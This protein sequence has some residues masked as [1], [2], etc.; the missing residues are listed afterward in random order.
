MAKFG[1]KVK[2]LRFLVAQTSPSS[3]G[4]RD[5]ILRHYASLKSANP[6]VKFM[7]RESEGITPKVFAR[8][9]MGKEACIS[10]ANNGAD[11][12]AEKLKFLNRT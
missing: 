2:E 4:I 1:A 5:Y 9:E 12:I 8:Y 10:I 11:E 7:V 3:A 6:H